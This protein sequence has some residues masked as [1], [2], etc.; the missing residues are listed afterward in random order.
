MGAAN[1]QS[2]SKLAAPIAFTVCQLHCLGIRPYESLLD[3]KRFKLTPDSAACIASMRCTSGGTRT[4][5]FP[6]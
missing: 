6:L 1:R 4:K 5:N 3:T 2:N